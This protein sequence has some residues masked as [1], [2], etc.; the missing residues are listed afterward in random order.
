[1]LP[2]EESIYGEPSTSPWLRKGALRITL[3]AM[4][5]LL[6]ESSKSRSK[7]LL[8]GNLLLVGQLLL[9]GEPLHICEPLLLYYHTQYEAPY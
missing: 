6:R 5:T 3:G 7:C 4:A 2:K 9:N 1:L 8:V